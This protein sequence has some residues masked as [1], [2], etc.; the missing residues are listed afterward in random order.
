MDIISCSNVTGKLASQNVDSLFT[1]AP[2]NDS[3]KLIINH[4]YFDQDIAL[5]KIPQ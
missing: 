3:I 1:N 4:A 5:P 2:L